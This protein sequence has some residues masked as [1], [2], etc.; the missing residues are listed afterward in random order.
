MLLPAIFI[1][2]RK[3]VPSVL[4]AHRA[5]AEGVAVA[6]RLKLATGIA[7]AIRAKRIFD[8]AMKLTTREMCVCSEGLVSCN[9]Y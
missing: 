6:H 7:V 4:A 1:R 8:P 3:T 2:Q 5:D 9:L